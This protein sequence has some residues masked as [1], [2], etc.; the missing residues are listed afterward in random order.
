[1]PITFNNLLTVING[2]AQFLIGALGPDSPLVRDAEAIWKA[3]ERAASLT[4]QLLAF[5]CP[6]EV[7]TR[8]LDL[9][10]VLRDVGE[11]LHSL[12]GEDVVLK[13]KLAEDLGMVK[14]NPGQMEVVVLNLV[15]NARE[16][17]PSGG[18]LSLETAN[19]ELDRAYA[20]RHPG[21]EPGHYVMITVSD[22]G[23]G[24]TPE[25][26]ERIFEPFFTTKD[27]VTR[28]GMGLATVYGIIEQSGGHIQ[29]F[30]EPDLGTT[31]KIYL[32]RV[33]D[34][35]QLADPAMFSSELPRA[36]EQLANPTMSSS[37]LPR[38]TERILVL[39]DQDQVREFAS[40]MLERLGYDVLAA[41]NGNDALALCLTMPT[42]IDLLLADVVMPS[43]SGPEFVER[44]RQL[45]RGFEVIYMSGYPIATIAN[46]GPVG[47]EDVVI[48]KPFTLEELAYEV[49]RALNKRP[50]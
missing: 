4:S 36:T 23:C 39:E 45:H 27:P 17:M 3:G 38:G 19:V 13:I 21:V 1:M 15:T 29:V 14:V 28:A 12:L 25:V 11:M 46:H 22:S 42:S 47:P 2:Y 48:Q 16:A 33:D 32:P 9:N 37:E 34:T 41:S 18:V 8:A 7:Q 43:M 40:E 6:T 5:G 31:F 49:R 10:D 50:A 30:S 44:L 35:R 24:M 26:R 20:A